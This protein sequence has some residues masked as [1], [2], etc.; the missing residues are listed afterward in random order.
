ME[1][2]MNLDECRKHFTKRGINRTISSEDGVYI[3]DNFMCTVCERRWSDRYIYEHTI[4][5]SFDGDQKDEVYN[6][7]IS[8]SRT[9]E[10]D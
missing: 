7:V 9:I 1:R 10:N 4:D 3:D 2:C 8:E 5:V 6:T